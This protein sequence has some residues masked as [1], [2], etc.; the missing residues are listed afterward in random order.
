LLKA[1]QKVLVAV[2]DT[3]V[4]QRAPRLSMSP[5]RR[6]LGILWQK[7]SHGA[8]GWRMRRMSQMSVPMP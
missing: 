8:P 4:G 1:S 6:R 5:V 3:P 7:R 2:A